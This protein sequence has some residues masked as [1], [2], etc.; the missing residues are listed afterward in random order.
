MCFKDVRYIE[1]VDY[2]RVRLGCLDII[3]EVNLSGMAVCDG[4]LETPDYKLACCD[5][6]DMCNGALNVALETK[7][8][9]T[10]T[11]NTV[12]P[13]DPTANT[14]TP[15]DPTEPTASSGKPPHKQDH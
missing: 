5:G 15:A 6:E 2:V 14:L 9:T 4:R 7:P 10:P 1:L 11:A 3:P 13:A 12:T 8:P